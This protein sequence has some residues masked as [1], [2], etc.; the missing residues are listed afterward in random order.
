MDLLAKESEKWNS[1]QQRRRALYT[2]D[3]DR[4]VLRTATVDRKS[5][6]EVQKA[7]LTPSSAG[8]FGASVPGEIKPDSAVFFSNSICDSSTSTALPEDSIIYCTDSS[9]LQWERGSWEAGPKPEKKSILDKLL[10]DIDVPTL[11]SLLM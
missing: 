2:A 4:G 10:V 8:R 5:A 9:A 7:C 11:E 6:V 1:G 3:R